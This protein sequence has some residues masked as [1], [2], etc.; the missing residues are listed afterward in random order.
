[1]DHLFSGYS[2]TFKT[3]KG[4]SLVYD[5]KNKSTRSLDNMD[6]R[7]VANLNKKGSNNFLQKRSHLSFKLESDIIYKKDK[8][9]SNMPEITIITHE[10]PDSLLKIISSIIDNVLIRYPDI[11]LKV[12]DDS[13]ENDEKNRHLINKIKN[14]KGYKILYFGKTEKNLLQ[15]NILSGT[16]K[17]SQM[18]KAISF[19]IFGTHDLGSV[20]GPG[21]N[22]NSSLLISA[23]KKIISFDDDIIINIKQHENIAKFI[24]VSENQIPEINLY[25]DLNMLDKKILN[26]NID[27]INYTTNILGNF[28][29]SYV[30]SV[31]DDY[32]TIIPENI[33]FGK[34]IN[35]KAAMLGIYGERWNDN[36]LGILLNDG[37]DKKTSYKNK[38]KYSQ[39][40]SKPVSLLL[41]DETIIT[42]APFFVSSAIGIDKTEVPPFPPHGRNEDGI[43]AAIIIAL[44]DESYISHSPFAVKH[45]ENNA[46]IFTE[47]DYYTF[48]AGFGL[49]NYL[50][51]Q[52]TIKNIISNYLKVTYESLGKSLINIS[53]LS[54][55]DWINLCHDLWLEY[56]GKTIEKLELLLSKYKRKPKHWAIDVDNYISTIEREI[57]VNSNALPKEL[58]K[59][60]GIQ[61]SVKL[62]KLFFREYGELLVIWP[63]IWQT[64]E[65]NNRI[66]TFG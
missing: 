65:R 41:H 62:H 64:A 60:H 19:A 23:G 32:N 45:S 53:H 38:Y 2:V 1:M 33:A 29:S 46:K 63:E 47:Q 16:K 7:K 42:R 50:L 37:Y 48:S 4:S 10:K 43:W 40:K 3:G 27:I 6:R 15:K 21:G 44:S 24:K 61:K 52:N 55:S 66:K 59:F 11:E 12:I 25:P 8:Y 13:I 39:I 26:S 28:P 20:P 17:N 9:C 22:R 49:S 54:D 5:L 51:I 35:I 36:L 58:L 31:Y 34:S 14:E 30:S 18:E 57:V 56:A